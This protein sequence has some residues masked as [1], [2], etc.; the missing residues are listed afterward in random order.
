MA[1]FIPFGAR[2]SHGRSDSIRPLRNWLDRRGIHRA[3]IV[4]HFG[5]TH[6]FTVASFLTNLRRIR[7]GRCPRVSTGSPQ[8]ILTTSHRCTRAVFWTTGRSGVRIAQLTG[9]ADDASEWW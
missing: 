5:S 9:K 7:E 1:S 8:L 2:A 3:S 4:P 6:Q